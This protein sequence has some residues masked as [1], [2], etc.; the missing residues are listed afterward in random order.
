MVD[1]KP[2]P[3]DILELQLGQLDLLMAMYP[4][5][6][7]IGDHEIRSLDAL[8]SAIE[9]GSSSD[10]NAARVI[11]IVLRLS[12]IDEGVSAAQSLQLDLTA[13]F[14]YEGPQS[15]EE[16][17]HI[18]V[19]IQQPSWLSRAAT[20]KLQDT[21]LDGDDLLSTIEDIKE[22]AARAYKESLQS[23]T[24]LVADASNAGPLLRVMFYFPSISTRSKVSEK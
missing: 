20:N 15:P 17:P 11:N 8:R 22:S 18:K 5:D 23:R 21:V 4:E 2:L 13:P 14:T 6:V 9:S 16:P 10:V 12:V 1:A 19:R 3:L 24:T 7:L